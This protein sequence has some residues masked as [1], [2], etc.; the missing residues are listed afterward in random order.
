MEI[1]VY[2]SYFF[3]LIEASGS[4]QIVTDPDLG[5]RSPKT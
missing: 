2:F 1:T 3:L 4:V 5:P